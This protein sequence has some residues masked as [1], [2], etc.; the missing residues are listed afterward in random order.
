MSLAPYRELNRRGWVESSS[1]IDVVEQN[2]LDFLGMENIDDEP[3]KIPHAVSRAVLY[4]EVSPALNAYLCYVRIIE[5][6]AHAD[7]FKIDRL[8]AA[9]PTVRA[10]RENT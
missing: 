1:D 4:S 9:L 2:V 7:P 3:E 5:R 10:L 6:T 8:C